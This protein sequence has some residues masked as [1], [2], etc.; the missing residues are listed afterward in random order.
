MELNGGARLE[1]AYSRDRVV[2]RL[3]A[4]LGARLAV[5]SPRISAIGDLEAHLRR[6][7]EVYLVW[8]PCFRQ[9][10]VLAAS[11][12]AR[13][14]G[15]PLVFDPLISAYDKQVNEREKFAALPPNR[16]SSGVAPGAVSSDCCEQAPSDSPITGTISRLNRLSCMTCTPVI[17]CITNLRSG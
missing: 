10:D 13:R 2:Y 17:A 7:G 8:V 1:G 4:Q 12:F 16:D 11:R 14:R 5:F 9:R 3:L 15:V 6:F